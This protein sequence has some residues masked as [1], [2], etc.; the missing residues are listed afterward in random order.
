MMNN[1]YLKYKKEPNVNP[2]NPKNNALWSNKS[3]LIHNP[4]LNPVNHYGYNKYLRKELNNR[5]NEKFRKFLRN[6]LYSNRD[7]DNDENHM[8][9]ENIN[10]DNDIY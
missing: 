4:I 3:N 6:Y 8:K 9:K 5:E 1:E 2:Y 10:K 7:S